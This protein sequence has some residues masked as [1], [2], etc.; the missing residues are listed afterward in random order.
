MLTGAV[1]LTAV[2]SSGPT[3]VSAVMT[4]P[5][6]AT[7]VSMAVAPSPVLE[8][9]DSTPI[10]AAPAVERVGMARLEQPAPVALT[11]ISVLSGRVSAAALGERAPPRL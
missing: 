4:E 1:M 5:A 2:L 10:H 3:A 7:T 11:A 9:L 6:V 8:H